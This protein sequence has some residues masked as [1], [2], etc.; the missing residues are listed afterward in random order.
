MVTDGGSMDRKWLRATQILGKNL[1]LSKSAKQ[2][3]TNIYVS[4]VLSERF[5]HVHGKLDH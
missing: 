1:A 5:D 3:E 2:I 4:D